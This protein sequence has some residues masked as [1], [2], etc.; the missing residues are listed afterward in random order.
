[1]K[2][3]KRVNTIQNLIEKTYMLCFA[4]IVLLCLFYQ[5]DKKR[6][7]LLDNS[8]NMLLGIGA[9]IIFAMA[10][11]CLIAEKIKNWNKIMKVLTIVLSFGLFILSYHYCFQTGWDVEKVLNNAPYIAAKEFDKLDNN[12]YSMYPNN[13]FLTCIF[14]L[15]Y[16]V[17][18]LM[19]VENGYYILLSMQSC[20][21]AW[22]GYFSYRIAD[23]FFGEEKRRYSLLVCI[24]K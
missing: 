3:V 7:F 6:I 14:S 16:K 4:I 17:A 19:H 22:T 1:M 8:F 24:W 11:S 9:Y 18:K 13:I 15:A 5:F 21:Y 20:I 23:M 10:I 2:K 12:Y